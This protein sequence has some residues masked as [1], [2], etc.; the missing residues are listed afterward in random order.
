[1]DNID[2]DMLTDTDQVRDKVGIVSFI[3]LAN[4]GKSTLVNALVGSKV[5]IV[6]KKA[7]TTRQRV[8]GIKTEA[9]SQLVFIDTPGFFTRKYRGEMAQYLR[10]EITEG[11]EGVDYLGV[12]IDA[13]AMIRTPDNIRIL[14]TNLKNLQSIKGLT[15]EKTPDA[16]IINKIDKIDQQK[17]LPLIKLISEHVNSLYQSGE[18]EYIPISAK[19]KEGLTLLVEKIKA[20]CQ[21]G[22]LIFPEEMV[23]LQSDEQFASEIIREKA[24]IY[25]KQELPYGV[26]V[27]C[28]SWEGGDKF[29]T[30]F[31]DLVVEKD[32]HKSIVLGKSG[33][34]IQ[35]IGTA[36]RKELERIYGSKFVLKLFV[37]V[38]EDW[39]RSEG[40]LRKIGYNFESSI[41]NGLEEND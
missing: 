4:A 24:F 18:V 36:A 17:L 8:L 27:I 16:I 32:S 39:T 19:S 28:R 31:A 35:D 38:E 25:L 29:E 9:D 22:P 10:H 13:E 12:V 26:G 30:V 40:G 23:T 5:S 11:V 1:M 3:G 7:Q 41:L 37:R 14:F 20:K 21:S 15:S 34:M 2:L 33:K 6:T